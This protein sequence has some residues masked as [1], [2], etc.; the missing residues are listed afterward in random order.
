MTAAPTQPHLGATDP[1]RLLAGIRG[2]VYRLALTTRVE[3]DRDPPARTS[4]GP[5]GALRLTKPIKAAAYAPPL[6]TQLRDAIRPNQGRTD[7]GRGGGA[8]S[9]P[10]DDTAS[11]LLATI[12]GEIAGMYRSALEL[13]P[14]GTSE[15]L[16]L[17]WLREFEFAY[18][19]GDVVDA[20]LTNY[21]LRIRGWRFTIEDHFTP[22]RKQEFAHCPACG[23]THYETFT[24]GEIT[25]QRCVTV[26]YY[27]GNTRRPP[28]A[29]CGHC[30]ARWTGVDELAALAAAVD[31]ILADDAHALDE[32]IIAPIPDDPASTDEPDTEGRPTP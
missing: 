10:Y 12:E 11:A 3:I 14:L 5:A 26:T 29:E 25:R 20:Q 18:R 7:S 19:A 28:V 31:S 4:R 1:E 15:Q 23:Y 8:Q 17:E 24:H 2:N 9:L 30:A 6:L 16:L 21:L 32:P 27:P 13:E 22:P